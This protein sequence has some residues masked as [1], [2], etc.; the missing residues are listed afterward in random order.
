MQIAIDGVCDFHLCSALYHKNSNHF[1]SLLK[2]TPLHENNIFANLVQFYLFI[3]FLWIIKMSTDLRDTRYIPHFKKIESY[4]V[5]RSILSKL[6]LC[7][8]GLLAY[9]LYTRLFPRAEPG[10]LAIGARFCF[11]YQIHGYN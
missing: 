6:M 3:Q 10:H 5:V 9:L 8:H 1:F 4:K 7:T 11:D 2:I